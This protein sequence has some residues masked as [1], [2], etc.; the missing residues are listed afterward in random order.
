MSCDKLVKSIVAYDKKFA[1]SYLQEKKL[2]LSVLDKGDYRLFKIANDLIESHL[3][4][5]NES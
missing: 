1:K 2:L 5:L 3:K 4:E